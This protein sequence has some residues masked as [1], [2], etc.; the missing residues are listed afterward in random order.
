MTDHEIHLKS[1]EL[2]GWKEGNGFGMGPD[3]HWFYTSM[4]GYVAHG[5][6]CMKMIGYWE[7]TVNLSQAWELYTHVYDCRAEAQ[8]HNDPLFVACGFNETL[9]TWRSPE[10]FARALVGESLR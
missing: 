4:D 1:A 9:T 7:P 2:M 6:Y 5:I 3:D 8:R 10:E